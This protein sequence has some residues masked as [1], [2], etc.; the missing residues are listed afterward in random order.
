MALI[1]D[2]DQQG[3][4]DRLRRELK[5]DVTIRFFTR[6]TFGLTIPGRECATC[7]DTQKLLQELVALS[8]KLH[9]ET[10]DFFSEP[11]AARDAGVERIPAIVLGSDG[12]SN[13]KFYGMPAGYE[14]ASLL[15]SLIAAS[16]GVSQLSLETRKK[17]KRVKAPVRILAF[18][19]PT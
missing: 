14:F 9:L 12:A 11:Q 2:K 18:V 13:A 4:K 6:K 3:L 5:R 16:R 10:K 1:S 8:P 17:L 15:E 7:D 19:T